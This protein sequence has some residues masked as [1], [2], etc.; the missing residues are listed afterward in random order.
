MTRR[1]FGLLILI[2]IGAV[3]G[4]PQARKGK[5]PKPPDLEVVEC[6]AHRSD[7]KI[8]VDGR[9]R[10]SGARPIRGLVLI[11]D[12]IATGRA[13]ITTQKG[14]VDEEVLEPGKESVFRMALTDPVRAVEIRVNAVDRNG[15]E[16][17]VA[18]AGPF[19]IE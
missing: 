17:N 1:W 3:P 12:F 16:L 7:G 5:T 2:V 4:A 8:A 19:P 6:S 11:F 18:K 9:V 13:V 10:N 15:R 14:S